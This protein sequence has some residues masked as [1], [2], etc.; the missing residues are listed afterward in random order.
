MNG[1]ALERGIC[2]EIAPAYSYLLMQAGVDATT[3][4][5]SD[6]EWSYV[7]I[8]GHEYHIDPTF[9][10][11]SDES[12]EYFMM[13]DEQRALSGFTRDYMF[14]TSNYTQNHPHPEYT[15]DDSTY[16][17]LWGS[18]LE[19]ILP[20]ENKLRCRKYTE[21]WEEVFFDFHYN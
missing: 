5:G 6:H 11:S 9:V 13:D 7:R 21:G 19:K 17:V 3:M 2:S 12:L 14:I 8:G 1:S 15:A 16:S 10:L 18:R 4:I 20:E